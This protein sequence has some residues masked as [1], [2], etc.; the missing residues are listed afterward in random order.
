MN[1]DNQGI[2]TSI[3]V[4][5]PLGSSPDE[6]DSLN[7]EGFEDPDIW[8]QTIIEAFK[9][10]KTDPEL[11]NV[12]GYAYLTEDRAASFKR[13]M[14]SPTPM[15]VN[16]L[17][18]RLGI[19]HLGTIADVGCGPGH[20]A[21]SLNCLGYS[22]VT[23]MDPNGR[24]YTGTGYLKSLSDH[25]IQIFNDLKEWRRIEGR[26]D[27]I[28]SSGTI[29]HWQHIPQIAID[30]RRVMKPGAYWISIS[31]YISYTPAHLFALVKYH[32]THM[33]YN[34]YEWAYPASAYVDLIQSVGLTL[35]GVIPHY[36]NNNEF[37]GWSEPIPPNFSADQLSD[38]VNAKLLS[39]G[40]TV[41][42]FWAEVDWFRRHNSGPRIYTS[43]QVLIFQ[44]TALW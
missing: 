44:R 42:K 1:N 17:L 18:G 36:Y 33:R 2:Q 23:A 13:F 22:C 12:L 28:V 31:E 40:G 6:M 29:H 35:V 8:E 25:N 11:A 41:E 37:L 10:A 14:E 20:M 26:Y 24:Y 30:T 19:G 4:E 21:Y 43:P 32:P 9:V 16:T 5:R 39:P 38:D 3:I 15:A 34:S 7:V 27:A